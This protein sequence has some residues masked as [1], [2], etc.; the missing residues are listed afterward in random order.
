MVKIKFPDGSVEE[1]KKGVTGLEIAKFISEGLARV[2]IAI[3]VNEELQ[4]LSKPIEKDAS[5]KIITFKDKEGVEIFR[6]STAHLMAHAVVELFPYAKP[7]I[8]PVVDEGFYYDFDHEPFKPED[9]EKIEKKMKELVKEKIPIERIELSKK[10]AL[11]MFK[12]NQ[13]KIEMINELEEDK[14]T[15]YKQ[16]KFVDLCKGPHVP[17]TKMIKAFKL[18]KIA[19]AYW[20]GD[21][22]NK[23]LTRIYGIAFPDKEDLKKYLHLIEEAKKRDHKLIGKQMELFSFHEEG[24]GF[25][26]FHNKGTFVFDKLVSFMKKEMIKRDYEINKTPIILNKELWLQ[27]GHW[28]HYRESMYFTKI[29]EK[30]FAVKPM[31]CPGNILVY[32]SRL[33]SYREL[34]IKAGEFGLVHRHELSG[35]L[36]GLFRVRSFVQDDAHVFCS[37]EQLEDEIIALMDFIDYIY[38]S[39][40]FRYNVELSTRPEKALG[41]KEV[42]DLAEK[43][44]ENAMMKRK[45][46][47]KINPG[48]GAFYGPKIDYH[49]KDAI[50]RT[51]Q[52]ATIQVDF[53]MPEKFDLQYE[54]KDG[55]KHR[56]VMV[57]RA[58]Y[59]AVERFMA[60]LIEHFAGK[61]PMWLSPIQ[62]RV[63]SVS[64][65]TADYA[66]KIGKKLKDS[67]LRMEIDNR[68]ETV[69]KKIR[70][71][72]I[73]HVN[74][75]LVVGE[76][77]KNS[78]TVNVRTRKNEILGEMRLADF[79]D[80]C[81]REVKE[82]R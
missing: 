24:P 80:K 5:V 59:G 16:G 46:K 56:P 10:Q 14:I 31:N 57:H 81:H 48:E 79:I 73:A 39:F 54:G 11:E 66:S 15:A 37:E 69:N 19:G 34:P 32:K 7:T 64:E 41:S 36:S 75:I 82:K 62:V 4:D 1:F 44:L 33:H 52:C 28:D 67:G 3:K 21:S 26:F 25:P 35:V 13:Y 70:E 2:A 60:I 72:E 71:A 55:K 6:H 65:K 40:G 53:S 8:G 63:L 27:S 23:M 51:W 77:E 61:F 30:D 68:S 76:R 9:I 45:M 43:S 20:R 50:G 29:D 38:Q 12:D 42:W 74:Y 18:T 78:R 22:K 58:I 49:L 47:Y 17:N